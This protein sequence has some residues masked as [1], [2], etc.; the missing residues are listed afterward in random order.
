MSPSKTPF[1]AL[2]R[3]EQA[4]LTMEALWETRWSIRE[5]DYERALRLL[6]CLAQIARRAKGKIQR[7]AMDGAWDIIAHLVAIFAAMENSMHLHMRLTRIS[8]Q[9]PQGI[10]NGLSA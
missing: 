3:D 6:R 10:E 7:T 1:E 5:G 9:L 4:S 8:G 2:P